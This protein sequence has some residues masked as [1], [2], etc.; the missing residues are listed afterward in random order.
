MT[1]LNNEEVLKQAENMFNAMINTLSENMYK[2]VIKGVEQA[3]DYI[4]IDK[5]LGD[6][7][8]NANTNLEEVKTFAKVALSKEKFRR[9]LEEFNSEHKK[10]NEENAN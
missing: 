6:L 7:E 1:I 5:H 4:D 10:G 3:L 8:V 2:E 9:V